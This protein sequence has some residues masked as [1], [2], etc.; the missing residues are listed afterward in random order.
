MGFMDKRLWFKA[1]R[2][3]YGWY[4]VT[5]EGW[6]VVIAFILL[7]E[8]PPVSVILLGIRIPDAQFVA[9]FLPYV[10][11]LTTL[12]IWIS[13]KKGEKAGWRWGE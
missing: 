13:V 11:V 6:L 2:Y 10:A 12:L 3:G 4:P 9:F 7:I 5:K 1:K 8:L